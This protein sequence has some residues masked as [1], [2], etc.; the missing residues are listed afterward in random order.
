MILDNLKK[1]RRALIKLFNKQLIAF[2]NKIKTEEVSKID[3]ET[4]INGIE[5]SAGRIAEA[6]K[7]IRDFTFAEDIVRCNQ[8]DLTYRKIA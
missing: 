6:A 2:V 5:K 8:N 7:Q 3:L 1:S 4:S